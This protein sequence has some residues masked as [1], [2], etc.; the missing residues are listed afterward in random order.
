MRVRRLIRFL[1]LLSLL[2][3]AYPERASAEPSAVY[4][5]LRAARPQ[6]PAV[7]VQDLLL[8]RDAFRFR[9]DSGVFQFLSPVEKRVVG[10]VFVGQGS[11]ELTPATEAERR[12][13][14]LVSGEKGIQK[15]SDRFDALALLFSDETAAEIERQAKARESASPRAAEVFEAFLR[16]ERKDFKTNFHL[17]ILAELLKSS[18]PS[19]G[20][21]LAFVDGKKLPPALLGVDPWGI[22][23]TGLSD[24][25]GGEETALFVP[26]PD[27]DGFWYLAHRRAEIAAGAFHPARSLADALHYTIETTVEKSTDLSGVATVRF[28]PLAP[29]L[30]VLPFHLLPALRIEKV[31]IARVEE[32]KPLSFASAAFV[33]ED[34]KEDADAALILSAAL[35][36]GETF[37]ARI[38]YRG[39]EVL[40]DAGEGNFVVEARESWYPNLGIFSDPATFDLTYRVPKIYETVSVGRFVSSKI[41]GDARISLWKAERPIRVAGFN[42]GKFKKIER[43]D[44]QTG[45]KLQVFTNPGTPD[46]IKEINALLREG[47]GREL[48]IGSPV[49]TGLDNPFATPSREAGLTHISLS[50]DNL[51]EAALVEGQNA[52]QVCTAYFGKLPEGSVSITQQAQWSFGQSWPSLIFLPFLAVLD[53]TQR[54]EFGL[55]EAGAFVEA[56]GLHEF[57]HQWWG[58]LVGWE[59]YRDQWLSEGLAEF[60]AALV[61]QHTSGMRRYDGFWENARRWILEK[62]RGAQIGNA[63]AGPITQGWRLATHRNPGAYAASVYSKGGYVIHMLRMLLREPGA[64]PDAKF[65]ALMKDFTGSFA[66]KTASTRD[67]QKIVER[68]MTPSMNATRDGK[69]DWFFDQW[70]RG[71]E[72]PRITEKLE[73]KKEGDQYRV[74][75]SVTQEGVSPGFRVLLPLYLE[76]GKGEI[77]SFGVLPLVGATTVPVNAALRLPKKPKRAFSNALHEVLTR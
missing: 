29:D 37:E 23:R 50:T 68:H 25:L 39:K 59:S 62:P 63:E 73:I 71:T 55:R 24:L 57:A 4:T 16:A 15:L 54:Q 64:D 65:R 3:A 67:F 28:Q 32:G 66:G 56:V 18:S 1:S 44:P 42:Y 6:G 17:R 12:H 58:H 35:P 61:L 11:W 34:A 27:Q 48:E 7:T 43:A 38:A 46:V 31:E 2:L 41:E 19:S 26:G 45:L 53:S 74:T 30:L 5:A 76:F 21:F 70:V 22:E 13:V 60:S 8:E 40:K 33:Q 36:P 51:A 20:V 75:G 77:V 9:F 72:I 14:E 52:A 47:T 49:P 69:M 10:A